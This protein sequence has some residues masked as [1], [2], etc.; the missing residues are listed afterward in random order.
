MRTI[1]DD[2]VAAPDAGDT[3][4]DDTVAADDTARDDTVTA[5]DPSLGR[6]SSSRIRPS[7]AAPA[8][9]RADYPQL[10]EVDP[11]HYVVEREIARGGMGR[12]LVAR[13]RRL[14]RDVA[15]KEMLVS[16]GRVARRFEREA[17]ISA[18]LQHPSIISV[19]EAGTWPSGEPFYAMRLV[20]GRSLDQAIAAA[21]SYAERLALLPSVLAVADAMAYAHG[22]G[23]IHRDLKPR[24]VVVGEFGETV[25]IDWGLAK[26][27]GGADLEVTP[28]PDRPMPVSGGDAGPSGSASFGDTVVGEVLGTPAYMPPEQANGVAVDARADVYAIGALLY[29][30]LTGRAPYQADSTAELL[31]AVFAGPPVALRALAPEAASELVAIVERSMA[32]DPAARYPT[33]RDLAEDLRRF[34]NGQLVGAHRYSLRHLVR[35]WIRRNRTLLTAVAAAAVVA[36]A[37]G[38][39]AIRRVVAAE[40]QARAERASAVRHQQDAEELMQFMLGDLREKLAPVG[41]LDLLDAVARRAVAYYDAR[42]GADAAEDHFLAATARI[43]LGSVIEARADLPGALAEY[44]QA[45]AVLAALVRAHPDVTKYEQRSM[46]ADNRIADVRQEQGDLAGALASFLDL[47]ARAERQLALDATDDKALQVAALYR[48]RVAK[49]LE[50]QGELEP[51]LTEF[52][53]ALALAMRRAEL[54]PSASA[55]KSLVIAHSHVARLLADA[56][57]DLPGALAGY[58]TGLAIGE[59]QVARAP[60]DPRWLQDV[61]LSHNE[62]SAILMEQRDLAGALA[63]VQAARRMIDRAIAIDPTNMERLSTGATIGERAG[64]IYL[65]QGDLTNA[66]AEFTACEA[67]ST[68]LAARDPSNLESQRARTLIANKLGDVR[69]KAKDPRGAL[70][71]YRSALPIRER[72]VATDPTNAGWR[73]DLFYSHYKIAKAQR[74]VP[75]RAQAIL[76][77]RAALAIAEVTRAAHPDNETFARDEAE[78]RGELALDLR[79][80]G[81]VAAARVEARAALAIAQQMAARPNASAAWVGVVDELTKLA[82]P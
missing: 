17:R 6:A 63:E 53:A 56:R 11:A 10:V 68:E 44:E 42:G 79:A 82:A 7:T 3:A 1:L 70:A 26:E 28:D 14:G 77:F 51:A 52:Q 61:A 23:V 39:V 19:H 29:H 50:R 41:K 57:H 45:A 20:T 43:A 22:Q 58:R 76:S 12:I 38:V 33:A 67:I 73:R 81:E 40:R 60:T 31:A 54:A 74:E 16:T 62:V 34:Q 2:T 46:D 75:D 27:L 55:D 32:R 36:I 35:R 66:T 64:M 65:A 71:A 78:T 72:L 8:A 48:G 21:R 80:G 59:R 13:D 47:R 37:I 5:D 4:R 9:A 15:V 49:V 25:V 69:M 30:L 24:N 18:R